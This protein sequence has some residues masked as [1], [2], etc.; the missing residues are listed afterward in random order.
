MKMTAKR[1]IGHLTQH[2]TSPFFNNNQLSRFRE[3]E[4]NG[5]LKK[6]NYGISDR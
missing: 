6:K 4:K 3:V 1:F 5:E 2:I